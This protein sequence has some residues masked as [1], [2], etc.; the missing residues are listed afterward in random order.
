MMNNHLAIKIFIDFIV[1]AFFHSIYIQ[2][3]SKDKYYSLLGDILKE[4]FNRQVEFK[5]KLLKVLSFMTRFNSDQK[6]GGIIKV[7]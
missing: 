4:K 3:I 7:S 6:P 2:H 1:H 5:E